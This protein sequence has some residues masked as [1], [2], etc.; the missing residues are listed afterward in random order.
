MV[1]EKH[2]VCSQLVNP[3]NPN[4]DQHLISP[5]SITPESYIKVMRINK[6]VIREGIFRFANKFSLSAP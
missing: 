3:L 4:S 5:Y 2:R 6:M 1:M